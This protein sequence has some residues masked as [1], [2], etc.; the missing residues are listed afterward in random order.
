MPIYEYQC[1][2]CGKI[3]DELQSMTEAPLVKCPKCGEDALKKLIGSGSGLIFKGSG[4]YLTDYKKSSG[5]KAKTEST[6][7]PASKQESKSDSK[8]ETKSETKTATKVETKS[9]DKK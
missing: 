4:F 7:K 9:T 2:K 6:E 3:L 8:S 5:D 1:S